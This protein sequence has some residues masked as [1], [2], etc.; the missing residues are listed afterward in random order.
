MSRYPLP[1]P[2]STADLVDLAGRVKV[3]RET[4]GDE[5]YQIGEGAEV[6]AAR[7]EQRDAEIVDLQQRLLG[8]RRVRPAPAGWRGLRERPRGGQLRHRSR[9]DAAR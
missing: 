6:L 3:A 5:A 7:L 8:I 2:L 1:S 9:G 4:C